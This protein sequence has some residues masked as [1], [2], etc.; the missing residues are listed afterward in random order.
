LRRYIKVLGDM[1]F[2]A[3]GGVLSIMDGGMV[4]RCRLTL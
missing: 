2:A 4:G 1:K 3:M